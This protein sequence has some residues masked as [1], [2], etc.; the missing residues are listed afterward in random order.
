[1]APEQTG[2]RGR[3][4]HVEYYETDRPD[5]LDSNRGGN[6]GRRKKPLSEDT[7]RGQFSI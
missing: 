6:G 7:D 5:A 2:K 1:M 4:T 3:P